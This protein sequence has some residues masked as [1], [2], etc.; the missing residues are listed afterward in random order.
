[1]VVVTVL[2]LLVVLGLRRWWRRGN[3]L[4]ADRSAVN[5]WVEL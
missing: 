5:E 2:V 3:E 4:Q 1:V